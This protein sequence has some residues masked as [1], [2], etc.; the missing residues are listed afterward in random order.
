[1]I[2]RDVPYATDSFVP[3]A[4]VTLTCEQN[5]IRNIGE[6]FDE[7]VKNRNVASTF[8]LSLQAGPVWDGK[9]AFDTLD[10]TLDATHA[11]SMAAAQELR[12]L[13]DSIVAATVLCIR[14]NAAR[15]GF[16]TKYLN[17]RVLGPSRL[18]D[19]SRVYP[20]EVIAVPTRTYDLGPA[21][22]RRPLPQRHK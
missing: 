19:L 20:I 12:A 4:E 10:V 2:I 1:M 3:G 9:A 11:D 5:A 13:P 6:D 18:Q 21:V 14:I 7:E 22:D 15:S 17:L 16:P 8:G